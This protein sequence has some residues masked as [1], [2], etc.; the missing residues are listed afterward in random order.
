[1]LALF[2]FGFVGFGLAAGGLFLAFRR[3]LR[4]CAGC[5]LSPSSPCPRVQ[6]CHK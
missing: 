5:E 3:S 1:M 6:A 2:C 4:R